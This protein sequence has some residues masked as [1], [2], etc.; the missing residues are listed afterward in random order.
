MVSLP[1]SYP[2]EPFLSPTHAT[3]PTLLILLDY[4]NP[5]IFG[6]KYRSLSSSLGSFLHSPVTSSLLDPNILLT[7]KYS[8]TLSLHSSLNVRDQVSNPYK[9]TGKIIVLYSLMFIHWDSKL[10]YKRF[11]ATVT[12][13][14]Q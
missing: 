14:Q 1:H 6:E 13:Y 5:V 12:P 10:E 7:T 11:C 2:P 4:I 8:N 3:F 9:T